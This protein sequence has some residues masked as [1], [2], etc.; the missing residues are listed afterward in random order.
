MN[1]TDYPAV[2]WFS[3]PQL[4]HVLRGMG[5]EVYD[6]LDLM[7]RDQMRGLRSV[8][9]WMIPDGKRPARGRWLFY[10]LSPTVSLYAR[11]PPG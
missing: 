1:Y 6:R 7:Q 11:R 3:Y 4:S 9:R 5:L 8:V 2:H 10:L